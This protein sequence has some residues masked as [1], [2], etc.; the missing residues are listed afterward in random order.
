MDIAS[1]RRN[2]SLQSLNESDVLQDPIEQFKR[3]FGEALDSQLPEPNA[4]VLSTASSGRVQSRT[5][6]LKGVDERGLIFY[7]NYESA[8]GRELIDNPQCALLFL[9]LELERQ[10]RIEGRAERI[11]AAESEAYFQSRPRSSQI[12]AW[13]S[14]QSAAISDRAA[15]EDKVA[16][17]TETFKH[18]EALPL[19]PFWGGFVVAP[20][21]FEFWQG[22]ESR[23]HDRIVYE[24]IGGASNWALKRLAP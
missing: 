16:E 20:D 5:V 3:W 2:Y 22:R 12:A 11:P 4:M 23:L 7:T 10:V 6:L 17:I 19:P 8:K 21:R 24:R 13:A 15:L 18:D 9:W 14:P 1:L